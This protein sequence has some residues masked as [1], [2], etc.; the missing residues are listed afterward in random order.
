MASW[1]R[2]QS[3]TVAGPR[4]PSTGFPPRPNGF[5]PRRSISSSFDEATFDPR[6]RRDDTPPRK[7]FK[8][9]GLAVA[10]PPRVSPAGERKAEQIVAPNVE[11]VVDASAE[12]Q[13]AFEH[14]DAEPRCQHG[15]RADVD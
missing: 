8:L 1:Q 2:I 6:K 9:P 5:L 14:V 7:E 3:P 11:E 10:D 15:S 12:T 4:R 13:A